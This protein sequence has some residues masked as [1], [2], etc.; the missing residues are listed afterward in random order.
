MSDAHATDAGRD[1]SRY[2]G[3]T[4]QELDELRIVGHG[5]VAPHLLGRGGSLRAGALLTMIDSVGGLNAG[6]AALPDGWVVSTN[7]AAQIVAPSRAGPLRFDSGLLRRGRNNVVTAVEVRDEGAA[8]TLVASGVLTSA[9]LVPQNGPPQWDR[10]LTLDTRAPTGPSPVPPVPEW[11]GVRMSDAD[12]IEIDLA[13]EHV[14]GGGVTTDVV[15][16]Y[17]APNRIGPIRAVARTV[18]M[19]RDGA[20][21]RVEVCDVGAART[22]AV[23]VVTCA[24]TG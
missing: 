23:A 4:M 18:G 3:M 12:A 2:M 15:L 6:L 9:I 1:V 11:L 22:T 16:H 7:L 5:A 8:D 17:L 13:A 21:L 24:T 14:T 19:R 10:P 20:V